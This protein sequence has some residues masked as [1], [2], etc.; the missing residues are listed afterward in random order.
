MAPM[1]RPLRRWAAGLAMAERLAG[2]AEAERRAALV[3]V[4]QTH[5]RPLADSVVVERRAA[6]VAVTQTHRR[7]LA[8]SVVVERRTGLATATR[9]DPAV[10]L[11]VI[12][13]EMRTLAAGLAETAE[14]TILAAEVAEVAGLAAEAVAKSERTP[15]RPSGVASAVLRWAS[16]AATP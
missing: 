12:A 6:L 5:R 7:P 13:H 15:L 3:A 9:A 4:T 8:D 2:L 1:A 10:G 14:V 16:W 11:V